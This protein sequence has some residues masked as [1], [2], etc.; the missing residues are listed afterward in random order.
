MASAS[1]TVLSG[2][3][4]AEVLDDDVLN[5][6]TSKGDLA[7]FISTGS[8]REH[9]LR[10]Y[11]SMPKRNLRV[12][13]QIANSPGT[14]P[15]GA[16]DFCVSADYAEILLEIS[17]NPAVFQLYNHPDFTQRARSICDNRRGADA[18]RRSDAVYSVA[19]ERILFGGD[20]LPDH[21]VWWFNS[22]GKHGHHTRY[23]NNRKKD[24]ARMLECY[25]EYEKQMDAPVPEGGIIYRSTYDFMVAYHSYIKYF[26]V[27]MYFL[28][29]SNKEKK[30]EGTVADM[31]EKKCSK[32]Q[33]EAAVR[34][35]Q[36]MDI[37]NTSAGEKKKKQRK[38]TKLTTKDDKAKELFGAVT[39]VGACGGLLKNLILSFLV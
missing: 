26:P 18:F 21:M 36:A 39:F 34:G 37:E 30:V 15:A 6:I 11:V 19:A 31:K 20:V 9:H 5:A 8:L 35:M 29:Q 10:V 17:N 38:L 7:Y 27:F 23:M 25:H 1:Y 3:P 22:R 12:L 2:K 33:I 13:R 28:L 16:V 24:G 4:L 32:E 14:N